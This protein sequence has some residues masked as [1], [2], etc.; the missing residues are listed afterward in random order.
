MTETED[1]ILARAESYIEALFPRMKAND[2]LT[3]HYLL[4]RSM[5]RTWMDLYN[6]QETILTIVDPLKATG[7]DLEH[8]VASRLLVRRLGNYATGYLTF[9]INAP[10][11]SDVIV[12][13]GTRCTAG[14]Y[15]FVTTAEGIIVAGTTSIS[16]AARSE[17]RGLMGNV[18]D[19]TITAMYHPPPGVDSV[20]NSL[21]FSGGTADETDD[22]LRNRFIDLGTLPGLATPEI[23]ERR[24][25]DLE[26][27]SEASVIS[28]GLGDVEI[29]VDDSLG[30]TANNQDV[31]DELDLDLAG[32]CQASGCI[33][34]IATPGG[35]IE[36][37][38]DANGDP[39]DCAGGL[40]WV[41]PIGFISVDDTFDVDYYITS[42]VLKTGTVTVP[43][44]TH[45]G[46]MISVVLEDETDRA[47]SIPQKVF[48][49]LNEYD[50]LLGMGEAGLL[51]NVPTPVTFAVAI[52]IVATDAP[53]ANLATNI[54]DSI[55]N[56]LSE[57]KI[58]EQVEWSDLR[59]CATIA[60]ASAADPE[61]R[62]Q[63]TGSERPFLGVNR[64]TN[65]RVTS[66]KGSA[67]RDGD[68]AVL[69]EDE[70]A[71]AGSVSVTVVAA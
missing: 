41:R 1:S 49:G 38:L 39:E 40:V 68:I 36:P 35:N 61:L 15:F 7:T 31:I 55:I 59:S 67:Q 27:I 25:V 9:S 37:V 19:Y 69:E 45:R 47:I 21:A 51:Y 28:K 23:I 57:Y 8:I 18:A 56:W 70:R 58:G 6:R 54:R 44:G 46:Q 42:E 11:S 33:A 53:E 10:I 48:A 43:I 4:N 66:S 34:A 22:E 30:I 50:V 12:P 14:D 3:L 5:A 2:R 71:I 24:L 32:G 64:I 13:A 52:T 29:I 63:L 60:Y 62:H 16:V 65:F 17:I 20:T 26:T